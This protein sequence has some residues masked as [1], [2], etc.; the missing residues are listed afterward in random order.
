MNNT[1]TD[2]SNPEWGTVSRVHNW[3][4]YISDEVKELWSTF[5]DQQKQALARMAQVIAD[6]ED[7]D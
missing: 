5:T 3:R 2:F 6:R 7:W 4:N 1:P